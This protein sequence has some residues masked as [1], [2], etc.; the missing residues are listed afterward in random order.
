M[1]KLLLTITA[2]AAM[3][4]CSKDEVV[5]KRPAQAIEF[6]N[7]FVENS[8]RAAIDGSYTKSK[9]TEFE[10]YGTIT[11]LTNNNTANIFD[12]ELVELKNGAWKYAE[13]KIQ[14]WIPGN[15]YNFTAIVDGN[16]EDVTSVGSNSDYMPTS[17]TVKDASQQK[18]VLLAQSNPIV[19]D[20]NTAAE[21]VCFT[22]NHL[23]SKAKFSVKNT[24]ATD[25]GYSY[26]VSGITIKSVAQNGVYNIANQTWGAAQTPGTYDLLFGNAVS[27]GTAAGANAE[28]IGYGKTM[29][30]NFE[31]L[32]IP[33]F[34]NEAT[35]DFT[36]QLTY[37][38]IYKTVSVRSETKTLSASA[39]LVAGHAY[40]FV[41]E[42]GNPG[43]PIEFTVTDA[44]VNGWNTNHDGYNP[45]VDVNN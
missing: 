45:G 33:T 22:F 8:T 16:V 26:K 21:T 37:E 31:R 28:E 39:Q 35:T 23:M 10:V 13:A 32:L 40:N 5:N 11:N 18:D 38:L 36:V 12:Q 1:K 42:L 14:Y 24:I 19:F 30:S 7:V 9:L 27:T 3:V 43:E 34:A 2:I 25:N 6:G 4:A 15:T 17:I 20:G 41:V 29:E 44:G